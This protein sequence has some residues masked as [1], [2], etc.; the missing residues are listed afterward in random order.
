MMARKNK[1]EKDVVKLINNLSRIFTGIKTVN[2][3]SDLLKIGANPENFSSFHVNRING[4]LDGMTNRAVNEK[5]FN[6]V[7]NQVNYLNIES[8]EDINFKDE[9]ISQFKKHLGAG[10]KEEEAINKTSINLAI[11]K[12]VVISLSRPTFKILP[13]TQKKD[14]DWSWQEDA[15]NKCLE[16]IRTNKGK[17]YGLVVPTG[18]GKTHIAARI[19][20]KLI[21]EDDCKKIIWVAHRN[22]LLEQAKDAIEKA[23]TEISNNDKEINKIIKSFCFSMVSA[24][25]ENFSVIENENDT[26]VIDEAHHG[27]ARTY[28]KIINSQKLTG[29]FLTA[30]PNRMDG[31]PIG[32][33]QIC[34]QISPRR[35]FDYGCIIEPTLTRYESEKFPSVFFN[36]V[37][38][39]EFARY[40]LQKSKTD[41]N[42]TLVCVFRVEEVNLLYD[43][44]IQELPLIE[45]HSLIEEDI[46]FAYGGMDTSI[47][48]YEKFNEQVSGILVATSSLVGEGLNLPSLDSVYIT[49]QSKSI[50]HL[51]QI[52]GRALRHDVGKDKATIIQVK[53]N[54][55]KYFFNSDWLYQDITDRLRPKIS[56]LN[57][58]DKKDLFNQVNSLMKLNNVPN[59]DKN[60]IFD[61][62]DNLENNENFRILFSGIRYFGDPTNFKNDAKW[63]AVLVRDKDEFFVPKF[64]EICYAEKIID[65]VVYARGLVNQVESF[66]KEVAI[67]FVDAT[68]RAKEEINENIWDFEHRG[69]SDDNSTTWLHNVSFKYN[70]SKN[71][72][73]EFLDDCS[74]KEEILRDYKVSNK[75]FVIKLSNPIA[76][77]FAI[78]LTLEDYE[79]LETYLT[80]LTKSLKEDMNKLQWDV[81]DNFNN[82]LSNYPLPLWTISRITELLD[83]ET[84]KFHMLRFD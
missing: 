16:A 63:H 84:R 12:G 21:K 40:I 47:D 31:K 52:A 43:A 7:M 6:A 69:I 28:K 70:N 42:K 76:L 10:L 48:F 36:D 71:K 61:Q 59:Y 22:F 58:T 80:H 9:I 30:T 54:D 66:T 25:N 53:T 64:N 19:L 41:F 68:N 33:D 3:L 5:T 2:G 1:S 35:L 18:G 15:I 75:K 77:K 60:S 14:P 23:A 56:I 62:L 57:Y 38:V 29:L 67:D 55:L 13:I 65:K 20:C 49:Y 45:G 24:A 51:L 8:Y 44:I 26:I 11:P 46:H 73:I 17:N 4:F 37:S 82:T 50:V 81:V 83:H 27:A 34:Y 39:Q 74:N 32:I 78:L 72:L 79:W